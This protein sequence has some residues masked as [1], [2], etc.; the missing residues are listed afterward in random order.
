MA[1]QLQ[2]RA[3]AL[4]LPETVE[5]SHFGDPDF[6]VRNKIF[7]GLKRNSERGWLKLGAARQVALVA[8]RP[9]AFA[10]AEGA[11]GRSGWTY[12]VL[13]EV[14]VGELKTMV[15]ESWRAIAPREL[16]ERYDGGERPKAARK[17]AAAKRQRSAKPAPR[18]R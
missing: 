13:P 9:S 11:W 18:K 7:A 15:E 12:V 1:T 16:V 17:P 8:S 4:S 10:P 14:A 3:L 2:M 5:K 6:R